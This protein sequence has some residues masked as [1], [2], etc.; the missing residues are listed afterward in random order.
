MPLERSRKFFLIAGLEG[1]DHLL[2]FRDSTLPLAWVLV[3]RESDALEARLY[4]FVLS[5]QKAVSAELN[6]EGVYGLVVLVILEPVAALVTAHHLIVEAS[7]LSNLTFGGQTASETAGHDLKNTQNGE[8][9]LYVPAGEFLNQGAPAGNQVNEAL[10]GEGFDGL[11]QRCAGDAKLL[12]Q[13][14]LVDVRA[15]GKRPLD[16]EIAESFKEFGMK[17]NPVEWPKAGQQSGIDVFR[18]DQGANPPRHLRTGGPSHS[19]AL[20]VLGVTS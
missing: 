7:Q 1:E 5:R 16:N 6:D 19:Y 11:A 8:H 2:M 10:A 3:A 14:D 15:G 20:F 13:L 17:R 12:A 9:L 4:A 18:R